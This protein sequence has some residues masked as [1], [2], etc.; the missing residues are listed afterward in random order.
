MRSGSKSSINE[1]VKNYISIIK[2][3]ACLVENWYF[4]WSKW[5]QAAST[6]VADHDC[7]IDFFTANLEAQLGNNPNK[8]ARELSA[9]HRMGDLKL[10][11][12]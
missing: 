2:P 12:S 1:T 8:P 7:P 9:A 10:A 5:V 11:N 4:T 6:A 3:A